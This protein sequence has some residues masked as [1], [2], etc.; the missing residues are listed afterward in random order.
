[1]T[2]AV[3]V[4]WFDTGDPHRL[5]AFEC[6][7][8]HWRRSGWPLFV[9]QYARERATARNE[10]A[11]AALALDHD[12]LVFADA[13]TLCLGEHVE[14]AAALAAD[15]PGLVYC[16]DLYVRLTR[17]TTA[18]LIVRPEGEW[19]LAFER[20]YYAPPSVGCVA[21]SAD[22]FLAAGG[23]DE[24]YRGW[25]Y[26]DL[27]FVD[28]CAEIA[29]IRRV[30][31][32]AFHLWHGERIGDPFANGATMVDAPVGSDREQVEA[33]RARWLASRERTAA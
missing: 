3:C 1:M 20:Q 29:P 11:H 5:A 15:A 28:A 8:A 21:I 6:V 19:P 31:G 13:D 25:G 17:E 32:P 22:S 10:A 26:E 7:Q 4:P 9:S 2:P 24:S 27:A 18:E 14:T 12:V 23:F 33:N 30:P 16:F